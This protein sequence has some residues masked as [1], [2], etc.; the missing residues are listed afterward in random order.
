MAQN[1]TLTVPS[2]QWLQLTDADVTRITFQNL[3]ANYLYIKGTTDATEP[4][5]LDGSLK[6]SPRQGER[7]VALADLFVGISAVRIWAY[8]DDASD[9]FVSHA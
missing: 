1:T 8:A 2:D 4:T 3:S 5:S 6:Y 9:V 7:N